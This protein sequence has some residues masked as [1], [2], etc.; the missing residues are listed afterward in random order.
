MYDVPVTFNV[1]EQKTDED[2]TVVQFE[3]KMVILYLLSHLA[4]VF[5]VAHHIDYTVF[6][7]GVTTVP[8][9]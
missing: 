9:Q 2:E 7:V 8:L 1:W 5:L 6:F 3:C 4:W